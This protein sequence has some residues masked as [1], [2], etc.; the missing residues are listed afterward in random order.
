MSEH[1]TKIP[2]DWS[3]QLSKMQQSIID[4]L[5]EKMISITN[6]QIPKIHTK[7]K[8]VESKVGEV[9]LIA[10]LN[11]ENLS[12]IDSRVTLNEERSLSNEGK[13]L[14]LEKDSDIV[15][16]RLKEIEEAVDKSNSSS[17][18]AKIEVAAVK[19]KLDSEKVK[20]NQR[21]KTLEESNANLQ[22]EIMNLNEKQDQ[23]KDLDKYNNLDK[24]IL[25]LK[26]LKH[27]NNNYKI[28]GSSKTPLVNKIITSE[29]DVADD[30][31]SR[32]IN[33][34]NNYTETDME[35][36]KEARNKVGIFPINYK[37]ITS[38]YQQLKGKEPEDGPVALYSNKKYN[39]ARFKAL[40]L[41]FYIEL[42]I[43]D[44]VIKEVKMCTNTQSAVMWIFVKPYTVKNVHLHSLQKKH[45]YQSLTFSHLMYGRE[46]VHWR[47]S[48][49][50]QD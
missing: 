40:E 5:S 15:E 31:K 17:E 22:K 27:S 19:S 46:S 37:H 18:K 38:A 14:Q 34:E 35:E 8:A 20:Q 44:V 9:E 7:I 39:N 2:D 3:A 41:F 48:S 13:V 30:D 47:L 42:G 32:D 28:Q 12:D 43:N 24:E 16:F 33:I 25:A 45:N 26:P 49:M 4:T 6:E 29:K 10:Q 1:D 21:I 23:G 50:R 36:I 11:K